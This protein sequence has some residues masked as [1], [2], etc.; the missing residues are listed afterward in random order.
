MSPKGLSKTGLTVTMIRLFNIR[1]LKLRS[2][3]YAYYVRK[4]QYIYH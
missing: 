1:R 3:Q 2:G 4:I